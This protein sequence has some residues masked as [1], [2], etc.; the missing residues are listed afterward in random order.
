MNKSKQYKYFLLFLLVSLFGCKFQSNPNNK[1]NEYEKET[2]GYDYKYISSYRDVVLLKDKVGN[3][4]VLSSPE[5]QG[6]VLTSTFNGMNGMS[7]GYINHERIASKELRT[8]SQGYG[9]EDRIWLGPQGGQF[10]IFFH[11][12]DDF[13]FDNWFTPSPLDSEPFNLIK[14]SQTMVKYQKKMSLTN[15]VNT[16]F[17]VQI[18]RTI[19]MID[20]EEAE[21][22]LGL[23]EIDQLKYVGFESE[24]ELTNIGSIAWKKE[25][26]LLSVWILG[27]FPGG[28]TIVIPYKEEAEKDQDQIYNEYF[29]ELL[30]SINKDQ[31]E[32]KDGKIFYN[33]SGNHIGKIGVGAKYIKP[34]LGSYDA[35]TNVLTVVNFSFYEKEKTYVNSQFKIQDEP[36][37]G[38]VVNA[39]NDGPLDRNKDAKPTFYEIESSSHSKEVQPGESII[40]FHRTFH[41]QGKQEQLSKI[42]QAL[43]DCKIEDIIQFQNNQ[44][45]H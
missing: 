33:G 22:I 44:I 16:S 35:N 12:G 19:R 3:S 28:S 9:G 37:N 6:Q 8:H 43:L 13:N 41:F 42:T 24:N 29:V 7:L 30:G 34:Y 18:D 39:Y 14:K 11:P 36:Y 27:M 26:G 38:D 25:T 20:I 15:Y 2:F 40:H 1:K 21:N 17:D 4:F 45:N 23:K 5:L 10:S 32:I 31:I